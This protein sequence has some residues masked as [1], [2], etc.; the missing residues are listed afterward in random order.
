MKILIVDDESEIC[1]SLSSMLEW[2]GF[3][4]ATAAN[5]L[6]AIEILKEKTFDIIMSDINM[7]TM[8]GVEL[9]KHVVTAYPTVPVVLMTGYADYNEE[10]L[11]RIGAKTVL[12]KPFN[13]KTLV[14]TL[15]KFKPTPT[16]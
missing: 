3:E 1:A 4:V 12:H 16:E 9:L 10:D 14:E 11:L 5:G 8:D 13:S 6:R 2:R 15:S 7:P